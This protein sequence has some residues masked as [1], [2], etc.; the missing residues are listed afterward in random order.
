MQ[1]GQHEFHAA[2]AHGRVAP[3]AELQ[4]HHQEGQIVL[5]VDL[6]QDVVELD[7][8]EDNRRILEEDVAEVEVAMALADASLGDTALEEV[9]VATVEGGQ[10]TKDLALLISKDQEWLTT[11]DFLA[12][13]DENLKKAMA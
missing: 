3:A 10:M 13:L 12:A 7:A 2:G 11:Q 9:C 1:S 4:V 5:D 6:R 8:V